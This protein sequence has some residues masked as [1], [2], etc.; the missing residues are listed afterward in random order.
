MIW[1]DVV[2]PLAVIGLMGRDHL[3]HCLVRNLAGKSAQS[4]PANRGRH[5]C[6]G[7]TVALATHTAVAKRADSIGALCERTLEQ[8][9]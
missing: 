3:L 8:V 2:A 6:T 7:Q 5:C 1:L 4:L 9:A